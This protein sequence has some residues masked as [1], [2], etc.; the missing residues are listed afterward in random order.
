M[1]VCSAQTPSC[2]RS[3][4]SL[5][6]DATPANSKEPYWRDCVVH[7]SQYACPCTHELDR[8]KRLPWWATSLRYYWP[9]IYWPQS[10]GVVRPY[11]CICHTYLSK[12]CTSRTSYKC[13]LSTTQLQLQLWQSTTKHKPTRGTNLLLEHTPRRLKVDGVCSQEVHSKNGERAERTKL[14]EKQNRGERKKKKNASQNF[15]NQFNMMGRLSLQEHILTHHT[16]KLLVY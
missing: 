9:C 3:H 7:I 2:S 6:P 8:I 12:L 5:L 16:R 10:E 13:N 1:R 15:A 4:S 14:R 11:C